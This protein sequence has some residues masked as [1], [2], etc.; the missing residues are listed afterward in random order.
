MLSMVEGA[1]RLD[2]RHV[3]Q[4]SIEHVTI[5]FTARLAA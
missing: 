1:C 5:G 2:A 3:P 4:P